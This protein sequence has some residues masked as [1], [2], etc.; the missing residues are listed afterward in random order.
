MN[1]SFCLAVQ[2]Q[3]FNLFINHSFCPT[4][5]SG[6]IFVYQSFIVSLYNIRF[7][8][9]LSVIYFVW[10][11]YQVFNLFISYHFVWLQYQVFNLFI[12]HSFCPTTKSGFIFNYQSFILSDCT[13][14]GFKFIYQSFILSDY[15]IRF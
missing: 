14:S 8:I 15:N 3:V 12:N 9:Y 1:L 13:I 6:F 2:Y 4:T 10:L 5:K 11:Q 7:Y